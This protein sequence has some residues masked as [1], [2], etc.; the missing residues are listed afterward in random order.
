[1]ELSKGCND[2]RPPIDNAID[3]FVV[4]S[5]E[6]SGEEENEVNINITGQY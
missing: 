2:F 1:L 4:E 6:S 3:F 5:D